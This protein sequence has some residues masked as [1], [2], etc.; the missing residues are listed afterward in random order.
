MTEIVERLTTSIP[1]S[2]TEFRFFNIQDGVDY[3]R[4]L[5]ST[6]IN[7]MKFENQFPTVGGEID[8]LIITRNGAEFIS[9]KKVRIND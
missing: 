5:I 3:S 4:H 2:L 1:D 6:T 8:T 7:Q 9:K